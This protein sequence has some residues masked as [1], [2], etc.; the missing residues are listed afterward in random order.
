MDEARWTDLDE[1][2][3]SLP[4]SMGISRIAVGAILESRV[5][6]NPT[7]FHFQD[8][9]GALLAAV[10]SLEAQVNEMRRS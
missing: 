1:L 3:L 9:I 2:L 6:G 4:E 7:G 10:I 5:D 8:A